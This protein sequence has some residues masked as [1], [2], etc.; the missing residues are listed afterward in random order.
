MGGGILQLVSNQVSIPDL[1]LTGDPQITFFKIL[2]RRTTSF[3]M[4]D[5]IINITGNIRFG[6]TGYAPIRPQG[7]MLHTLSLVVDIPTPIVDFK[8]PTY[9]TVR[10]L[11]IQCKLDPVIEQLALAN[12]DDLDDPV[13][14]EMLFG[15]DITDPNGPLGEA[16]E[17]TVDDLD[18]IYSKRLEVLDKFKSN[19]RPDDSRFSGRYVAIKPEL[20]DFEQFAGLE[21]DPFGESEKPIDPAGYLIMK[22]SNTKQF[23]DDSFTMLGFDPNIRNDFDCQKFMYDPRSYESYLNGD[24][25]YETGLSPSAIPVIRDLIRIYP[26]QIPE[27]RPLR[28]DTDVETFLSEP[29]NHSIVIPISQIDICRRV[30]LEKARIESRNNRDCDDGLNDLDRLNEVEI[31]ECLFGEISF[32]D[33]LEYGFE[34]GVYS[35]E[36]DFDPNDFEIVPR[37]ISSI[38]SSEQRS[39]ARSVPDYDTCLAD[40]IR[41]SKIRIPL[42]SIDRDIL[43]ELT[44]KFNRYCKNENALYNNTYDMRVPLREPNISTDINNESY[45]TDTDGFWLLDVVLIDRLEQSNPDSMPENINQDVIMLTPDVDNTDI[46]INPFYLDARSDRL[47]FAP[48][49]IT[50]EWVNHIIKEETV[51]SETGIVIPDNEV[52]LDNPTQVQ[53]FTKPENIRDGVDMLSDMIQEMYPIMNVEQAS[54][55]AQILNNDLFNLEDIEAY[56]KFLEAIRNDLLNTENQIS[57]YRLNSTSGCEGSNIFPEFDKDKKTQQTLFNSIDLQQIMTGKLLRDI[58]YVDQDRFAKQYPFCFNL[59]LR[60]SKYLTDEPVIPT[61]CQYIIS[62]KYILT[63]D[64]NLPDREQVHRLLKYIMW[65]YHL[66]NIEVQSRASTTADIDLG[67]SNQTNQNENLDTVCNITISGGEYFTIFSAYDAIQYYVWMDTNGDGVLQDPGPIVGALSTPVDIS[68][69]TMPDCNGVALAISNVLNG[70]ADFSTSIFNNDTIII[71]HTSN[72]IA[73]NISDNDTGFVFS[74]LYQG[75]VDRIQISYIDISGVLGVI[76]ETDTINTLSKMLIEMAVRPGPPESTGDPITYL[77]N[78]RYGKDDVKKITDSMIYEDDSIIERFRTTDITALTCF[79]IFLTPEKNYFERDYLLSGVRFNSDSTINDQVEDLRDLVG[80]GVGNAD[81]VDTRG[82]CINREVELYHVIRTIDHNSADNLSRLID[83]TIKEYFIEIIDQAY[84]D[85]RATKENYINTISYKTI[86]KYLDEFF[87]N[88]FVLTSELSV[89]EITKVLLEIAQNTVIRTLNNFNQYLFYFWKNSSYVDREIDPRIYEEIIVINEPVAPNER[90]IREVDFCPPGNQIFLTD[91]YPDR[92]LVEPELKPD[93]SKA[94]YWSGIN[95]IYRPRMGYEFTSDL[96][97]DDPL[98]YRS[99]KSTVLEEREFT[100]DQAGETSKIQTPPIL[101][102]SDFRDD[103]SEYI[104]NQVNRVKNKMKKLINFGPESQTELET[105][106]TLR[107]NLIYTDWFDLQNFQTRAVN[108]L[109]S[110]RNLNSSELSYYP[111]AYVINHLP[112]T[113]VYYYGLYAQQIYASIFPSIKTGDTNLI[114]TLDYSIIESSDAKTEDD[115]ATPIFNSIPSSAIPVNTA[116]IPAMCPDGTTSV[117]Q[118][119]ST[120]IGEHPQCPIHGSILF[121]SQSQIDLYDR[122]LRDSAVLDSSDPIYK[123]CPLCVRTYLMFKLFDRMRKTVFT[124]DTITCSTCNIPLSGGEYFTLF[125]VPPPLPP[126][127]YYVWMDRNGDGVTQDPMVAGATGIRVDISKLTLLDFPKNLAT[128]IKNA[129]DAEANF[130]ASVFNCNTIVVKDVFIFMDEFAGTFDVVDNGTNFYF[131]TWP[132]NISD[133]IRTLFIDVSGLPGTTLENDITDD[134]YIKTMIAG[135]PDQ[136]DRDGRFKNMFLYRPEVV[137]YD[138]V[139]ETYYDTAIQFFLV[140]YA[141]I[142]YRYARMIRHIVELSNADYTTFT[143]CITPSST[144][145]IFGQSNVITFGEY[146]DHLDALRGPPSLELEFEA[147]IDLFCKAVMHNPSDTLINTL[148]NMVRSIPSSTDPIDYTKGEET[149]YPYVP[150]RVIQNI[151]P[152]PDAI[153]TDAYFSI[154]HLM[155]RGNISAWYTIQR[156]IIDL[157]NEYLNNL[158]DPREI[159]CPVDL[160]IETYNILQGQIPDQYTM[161]SNSGRRL[162]DFYRFKQTPEACQV[163]NFSEEIGDNIQVNDMDGNIIKS[164]N[165][166][167]YVR[168]IQIY[169]KMILVRYEKLRFLLFMKNNPLDDNT[170]YF[171][172]SDI[173]AKGFLDIPKNKIEEFKKIDV[174]LQTISD[175]ECF[176]FNDTSNLYYIDSEQFRLTV[177]RLGKEEFV[178]DFVNFDYLNPFHLS[179]SFTY[180]Q[181]RNLLRLVGFADR[182][183]QNITSISPVFDSNL[184]VPEQLRNLD[185]DYTDDFERYRSLFGGSNDLNNTSIYTKQSLNNAIDPIALQIIYLYKIDSFGFRKI[186]VGLFYDIWLNFPT[187]SNILYDL[188][189]DPVTF[190]KYEDPPMTFNTIRTY[191]GVNSSSPLNILKNRLE[192]YDFTDPSCGSFHSPELKDWESE[193]ICSKADPFD[194]LRRVFNVYYFLTGACDYQDIYSVIIFTRIEIS[195]GTKSLIARFQEFEKIAQD[196]INSLSRAFTITNDELRIQNQL[197]TLL[198]LRNRHISTLDAIKQAQLAG[199]SCIRERI[200]LIA[201]Q[202]EFYAGCLPDIDAILNDIYTQIDA[203]NSAIT[204]VTIDDILDGIETGIINGTI[205]DLET[206]EAIVNANLAT[207]EIATVGAIASLN[208]KL[209]LIQEESCLK[210]TFIRSAE[211]ELIKDERV[212]TPE[213][214]F[215]LKELQLMNNFRTVEDVIRFL[216]SGVIALMTPTTDEITVIYLDGIVTEAEEVLLDAE[217]VKIEQSTRY[218]L[219][220]IFDGG[221]NP[222]LANLIGDANPFRAGNYFGTSLCESMKTLFP[223][224]D[225][226]YSETKTYQN[227]IDDLIRSIKIKFECMDKLAALDR[228]KD[229]TRDPVCGFCFYDFDKFI[230]FNPVENIRSIQNSQDNSQ[231]FKD[232]DLHKRDITNNLIKKQTKSAVIDKDRKSIYQKQESNGLIDARHYN[233]K[234][235]LKDSNKTFNRSV[236]RQNQEDIVTGQNNT[237]IYVGS[238]IYNKILKILRLTNDKPEHA[239]VR[240]LGIRMIEELSLVIDGEEI[241]IYNPELN[242]LLRKT[243]VSAEQDRGVD[244]MNGHIPEMYEISTECRPSMK[245]YINTWFAFSRFPGNSLPLLNMLYSKAYLKVKLAKIEDLLYIEPCGI[246]KKPVKIHVNFLGRYIYLEEEER[247][248]FALSRSQNIMERYRHVSTIKTLSDIKSSNVADGGKKRG[249]ASSGINLNN[250]D[251]R[252]NVDRL[253]KQRYYFEDPTKFLMWRMR[254]IYPYPDPKDKIYWDI[255]AGS[256]DENMR[257]GLLDERGK[258]LDKMKIF[259]RVKIQMNSVTRDNFR[260]EEYYRLYVPYKTFLRNLDLNEGVYTFALQLKGLGIQPPG[261][262]NLTMID[263]LTIFNDMSEDLVRALEAGARLK[264]D[265]FQCSYNVF[266]AMSGFGALNFYGTH[267]S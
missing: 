220:S 233:R 15:P 66:E 107:E 167:N 246:L 77:K 70:L 67:Q 80:S 190:N 131:K 98:S 161:T 76:K 266:I 254:L 28:T 225:D 69:L 61:S 267:Y 142:Y 221:F 199:F 47:D 203:I 94:K 230:P 177:D 7:D 90:C 245:L 201:E 247:K 21:D 38:S 109:A 27:Y 170:F 261:A 181:V 43:I 11:L 180:N 202:F 153:I 229:L 75:D 187:I 40:L 171:E 130:E 87:A 12:G 260:Q 205:S 22:A 252:S 78:T 129:I 158:S 169:Y 224:Y 36:P 60:E 195:I 101:G 73:T 25:V 110:D 48:Y 37:E 44:E 93:L 248:R 235:L 41:R 51:D 88:I 214:L 217:N 163:G 238:D 10:D 132:D 106:D 218:G 149:I 128:A 82:T 13:T 14:Y 137:H 4:Q 62:D 175:R 135:T 138:E 72:G 147:E 151:V 200:D 176:F 103:Y 81:F 123:E 124:S 210:F 259:D 189:F 6:D 178:D 216:I 84:E 83:S 57:D 102:S 241:D 16:F 65:A 222:I 105:V 258:L 236:N 19:Y 239:W 208:V 32:N 173:I 116:I 212:H 125:S 197:T 183:E 186:N 193:Y 8:D 164:I 96:E 5:S 244:I 240:Q 24:S 172:K 119:M 249:A 140:R 166:I 9:R 2:Y 257:L 59:F 184:S 154:R 3:S 71:Q 104:D 234:K 122:F 115:N 155:Y 64:P 126:I 118:F 35:F 204:S 117:L 108:R 63:T 45:V 231:N 86:V 209:L 179:Q 114:E 18:I 194:A 113:L 95:Q 223:Q 242:L 49:C 42:V 146:V 58:I 264:I 207:L 191:T 31:D 226:I 168:E 50:R 127:Q 26:R 74:V 112:M 174:F 79:P 250:T 139:T 30:L 34:F 215:N 20:I 152:D 198:L 256:A 1:Y 188:D 160:F 100:A 56:H 136:P 120:D 232:Y 255:A 206:L 159:D 262:T 162:I 134:E 53:I 243:L 185:L 143:T 144:F 89:E 91:C 237:P 213:R 97:F 23:F 156:E 17:E 33:L 265:M 148:K 55:I 68:G 182:L 263:N 253:I 52:D 111:D 54:D 196:I 192:Q 150:E 39:F 227:M 228:Y 251:S 85:S 99:E 121:L 157:Y 145:D 165:M 133:V 29:K 141:T 211:S 46:L 219:P 92:V